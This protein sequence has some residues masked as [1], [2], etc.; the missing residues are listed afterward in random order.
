M[1]TEVK[2]GKIQKVSFGLGGYQDTMLGISLMLGASTW[3]THYHKGFWGPDITVTERTQWTEDDRTAEF[4]EL[5]H[6]VGELLSNAN[7]KCVADLKNIP[8]E[9]TFEKNVLKSWRIL[10][11]VI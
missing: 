7:V 5:V 4:A 11:E 1:S 9:V 10:E 2:L 6:Y 8:I 3:S